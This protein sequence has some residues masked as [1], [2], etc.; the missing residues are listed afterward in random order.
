MSSRAHLLRLCALCLVV[1]GS[2]LLGCGS[3][4]PTAGATSSSAGAP[5]PLAAAP[6]AIESSLSEVPREATET[7]PDGDLDQ[8]VA[9]NTAFALDLFRATRG[10][11]PRNLILSPNSVSTV[12]AMVE[13]GAEA[14]TQH[15]IDKV[16]H[17]TLGEEALHPAFNRLQL[18][19]AAR[20]DEAKP[21]RGPDAGKEVLALHAAEG[22]FGSPDIPWKPEFLDLLAADYGAGMQTVDFTQ[23]EQARAL[24]NRWVAEQTAE[25]IT[26][27]LPPGSV[28]PDGLP[29]ELVLL[30]TLYLRASW[31]YPFP[32]SSP[33][34]FHLLDGSV[35]SVDTLEQAMPFPSAEGDGWRALELPYQ[36]D[37]LSFV[38]ILPG[39]G[40]FERFASGLSVDLLDSILSAL[41]RDRD[42][43][44][45]IIVKLPKFAFDS[46]F[47]L[48]EPLESLGLRLAFQ[49]GAA[50]FSAM[51]APRGG[52]WIDD[53]YHGATI[54]V[55]ER[56][57]EA[58]A[59]TAVVMVAGITDKKMTIDRP[60]VF[61]I[62]DR[63]TGAIL[64]LGQ[65]I[66][67]RAT[68]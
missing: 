14:E 7:A 18:E 61:L 27:I 22:L 63:D 30:N 11:F 34:D 60:F 29:T 23:T 3:E 49:K 54:A 37:K 47:K 36:G 15:E 9:G 5:S 16:L 50:D 53:I 10:T 25:R 17:Y 43:P 48:K 32:G 45:E 13:A 58:S 57:T 21:A 1:L 35:V 44:D 67:P 41:D 38:V 28:N 39:E 20:P 12:M 40:A 64:F 55:D 51:G 24:I 46:A 2:L 4:D 59:A 65:V 26:E 8:L 31:A 42:R 56:G 62:R 6:A 66:D 68:T 19:L 33:R 52:L